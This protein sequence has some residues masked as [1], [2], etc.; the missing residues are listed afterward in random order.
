MKTFVILDCVSSSV[1][2][3]WQTVVPLC[4]MSCWRKCKLTDVARTEWDKI[5]DRPDYSVWRSSRLFSPVSL[6]YLF[7]QL[8]YVNFVHLIQISGNDL[9]AKLSLRHSAPHVF[10]QRDA[11]VTNY[12]KSCDT[13]LLFIV[14]KCYTPSVSFVRVVQY[15]QLDSIGKYGSSIWSIRSIWRIENFLDDPTSRVFY[16]P[17]ASH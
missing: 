11:Q 7:L 16:L 2:F 13:R 17:F 5:F 1:C 4:V 10:T 3:F 9:S 14:C 8:D 15:C 12:L 6:S